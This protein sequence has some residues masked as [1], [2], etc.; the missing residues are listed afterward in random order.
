MSARLEA[1]TG[2]AFFSLLQALAALALML[3][4]VYWLRRLLLSGN[5]QRRR[6]ERMQLEERLNL[7]LRNALVVVRVEGRRLLL[8]TGDH[9][10]ARLLCEL[11]CTPASDDVPPVREPS[12]STRAHDAATPADPRP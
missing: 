1:S 6:S 3:A 9:G 11:A 4:L 5:L 10:P 7:D 12:G 2:P 8:A